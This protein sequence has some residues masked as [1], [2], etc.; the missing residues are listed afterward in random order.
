M[1]INNPAGGA[2]AFFNR[3]SLVTRA[4]KKRILPVFYSD[5]Y[6]SVLPG[7]EKTVFIDYNQNDN[8]NNAEVSISGWNVDE[9]YI[10]IK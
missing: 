10:E 3:V 5:N 6:F 1:K 4:T 7:E 2:L 8:I 9:Q